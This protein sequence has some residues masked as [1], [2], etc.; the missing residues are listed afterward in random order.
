MTDVEIMTMLDDELVDRMLRE[1][2]STAG[3]S[4]LLDKLKAEMKRRLNE[5]H[6]RTRPPGWGTG[7]P[8][9]AP[10]SS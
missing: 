8:I 9:P 7:D 1:G 3:F 2:G 10:Q 4:P 5:R 6:N